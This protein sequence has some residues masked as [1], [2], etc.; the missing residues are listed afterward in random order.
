[1]ELVDEPVEVLLELPGNPRLSDSGDPEH[2]DEPRLALIRNSV[3][4]VLDQAE[5]AF[6]PDERRLEA[7]RATLAPSRGNN[8]GGAPERDRLRL[9]T[10]LVRARL[11]VG[12]CGLG[13][14]SRHVA[15]EDRSRG[16][17]RLNARGGV[18]EI[19]GHE[20][21]AFRAHGDRRFAGDDSRARLQPG[22]AGLAL[23]RGDRLDQLE[24][25]ANGALGVVFSCDRCAPEG[26]HRVADELLDRASVAVD[27]LTRAV[28][29][30]RQQLA[31]LLGIP[32]L[33]V[34][35]EAHEVGEEDGD[36]A[37]LRDGRPGVRSRDGRSSRLERATAVAAEEIARVVRAP[38]DRA[39]ACKLRSALRA[40]AAPRLVVGSTVGATHDRGA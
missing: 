35:G 3:E 2:R 15:D 12:D 33:G 39:P 16:G 28:E 32:V 4:G 9:S 8:L 14:A 7:S 36:E 27:H 10:Y 19:A 24:G 23:Q 30:A 17:E 21:L 34:R 20:T 25:G 18:H 11:L 29:V 37:P 26:H 6:A 1:M 40:E 22:R 5:L 31:R 38:A 13:R